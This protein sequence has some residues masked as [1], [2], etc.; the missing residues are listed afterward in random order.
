MAYDFKGLESMMVT[1]A[2]QQEQLRTHILIRKQDAEREHWEW[3]MTF[4]TQSLPTVTRFSNKTMSPNPS[5]TV[6]PNWDQVFKHMSLRTSFS[7]RAS[8]LGSD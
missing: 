8:R 7:F 5:Q 6:L 3:Y 1:K 2:W 4:E